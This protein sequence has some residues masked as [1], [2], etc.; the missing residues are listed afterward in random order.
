MSN[1][2]SSKTV[3]FVHYKIKPINSAFE[4]SLYR[5]LL[6]KVCMKR[7]GWGESIDVIKDDFKSP[8]FITEVMYQF[9]SE[10]DEDMIE[11]VGELIDEEI[12]R[13]AARTNVEEII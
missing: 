7:N 11:E 9:V 10:I 4:D 8:K 6:S 1:I 3:V 2:T 12:S 13:W 5:H